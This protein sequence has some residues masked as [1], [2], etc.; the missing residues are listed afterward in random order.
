MR[1]QGGWGASSGGTGS[2]SSAPAPP[3]CRSAGEPYGGSPSRIHWPDSPRRSLPRWVRFRSASVTVGRRAPTRSASVWCE[4]R[5]GR[6]APSGAFRPHSSVSCQRLRSRRS[7]TPTVLAI[8]ALTASR[9][10]RRRAR[11]VSASQELGHLSGS[12]R[13]RLVE[14]RDRGRLDH[15]P[16]QLL[17]RRGLILPGAEQVAPAEQLEAATALG[18]Q[19]PATDE[20]VE[21]QEAEV[22]RGG[23]ARVRLPGAALELQHTGREGRPA[24]M[25]AAHRRRQ[26]RAPAPRPARADRFG[27]R[28]VGRL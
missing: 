20:A 9:R 18:D 6:T 15:R 22:V 2:A 12:G 5:N 1:E 13:E 14:H 10:D 8:A 16:G 3:E 23:L 27:P 21:H 19:N 28:P 17:E 4:S 26:P 7:S 25:A 11:S 24:A